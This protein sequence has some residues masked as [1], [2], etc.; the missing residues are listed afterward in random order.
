MVHSYRTKEWKLL[1]IKMQE[2]FNLFE[3]ILN[4]I[5]WGL[6]TPTLNS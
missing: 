5:C 6:K 3:Y 2:V 1:Q 4:A